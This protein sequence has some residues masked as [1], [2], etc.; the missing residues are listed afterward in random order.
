MDLIGATQDA[1]SI[2]VLLDV[3]LALAGD[4]DAER[5]LR[6]AATSE[7]LQEI[8]AT[9]AYL[10]LAHLAYQRERYAEALAY[11]RE[12]VWTTDRFTDPLPQPQPRI[13]FR[14]AV[15]ILYLWLAQAWPDSGDATERAVELLRLAGA[16]VRAAH[17]SPVYGA[18][19]MAGAELAA[20]RGAEETAREL[21]ALGIRSGATV[22]NLFP[23][24]DGK[25]LAALHR[26]EE[27]G[28]SSLSAWRERPFAAANARIAEL[29]TALLA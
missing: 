13:M 27:Q 10:G 19:A 29:M 17:D 26:E 4:R 5:R 9:Q 6:D 2:R 23:P 1:R 15:A 14:V 12:V 28:E 3:Q 20:H 22:S 21:R 24:G 25:R 7:Q 8:D 11:A 18:W 16:E